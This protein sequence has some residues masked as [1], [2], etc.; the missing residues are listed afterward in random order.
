MPPSKST[1]MDADG[2]PLKASAGAP[3]TPKEIDF[4]GCM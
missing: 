3:V 4:E 2:N 1:N